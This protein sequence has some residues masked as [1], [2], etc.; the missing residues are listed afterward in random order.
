[1]NPTPSGHG[2]AHA[3][4]R[5]EVMTDSPLRLVVRVFGG[6][7]TAID[8]ARNY[9]S[10]GNLNAYRHELSR[11]NGL[12]SE[13]MAALDR[14]NGGEVATQLESLYEYTLTQLLRP[15]AQADV[16]ALNHAERVLRT[17]KEAFDTVLAE[18]DRAALV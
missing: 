13:L 12:V 15:R 5:D 10:A 1:M 8:R 7:L 6:A 3:Y 11:A 17:L 9:A 4:R 18:S 14:D 2:H 16:H